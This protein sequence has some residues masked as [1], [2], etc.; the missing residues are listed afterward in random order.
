MFYYK[1]FWFY[2]GDIL[3]IY[4]VLFAENVET[5][6]EKEFRTKETR[7]KAEENLFKRTKEL[8]SEHEIVQKRLNR[9]QSNEVNQKRRKCGDAKNKKP[10]K[11]EM[12]FNEIFGDSGASK[13]L[14]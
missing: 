11:S 8:Q 14:L 2:K 3:C 6:F 10:I 12:P 5:V 13:R 1:V 4:F 7:N 9:G